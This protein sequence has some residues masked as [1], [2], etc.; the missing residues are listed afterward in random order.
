MSRRRFIAHH[1]TGGGTW[2]GS[3][4]SHIRQPTAEDGKRCRNLMWLTV[5][6]AASADLFRAHS[7][8][9]SLPATGSEKNNV[10]RLRYTALHPRRSCW[11]TGDG[12][13]SG[14]RSFFQEP[15]HGNCRYMSL[16]DISAD[17][18]S[19]ARGEIGRHP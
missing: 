1:H 3:F 13:S 4:T 18:G 19:V 12:Q 14:G 10:I 8:H 9:K 11:H 2:E 6:Q 7:T 16:Q 5:I 17:L 15:S